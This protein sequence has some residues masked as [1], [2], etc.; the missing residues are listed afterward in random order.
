MPYL[1]KAL[2]V[3]FYVPCF[4]GIASQNCSEMNLSVKLKLDYW[5]FPKMSKTL[6]GCTTSIVLYILM[7]ICV[8]QSVRLLTQFVAVRVPFSHYEFMFRRG[9]WSAAVGCRT[10]CYKKREISQQNIYNKYL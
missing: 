2:I 7:S 4:L 3:L 10:K 1:K 6:K 8:V 5:V 9:T